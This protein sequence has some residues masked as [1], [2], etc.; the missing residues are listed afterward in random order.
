MSKTQVTT[1]D[2][3]DLAITQPKLEYQPF[4][5]VRVA[6]SDNV[7]LSG[8]GTV[9]EKS[10]SDNDLVL[11]RMQ[12]T[13][14]DNGIYRASSSAWTKLGPSYAGTVV[15]IQ[16]GAE[17]ERELWIVRSDLITWDQFILGGVGA[18]GFS[19]F[20]GTGGGGG[21]ESGYSGSSGKSGTSGYSGVAGNQGSQGT[22]G[23]S[24]TSGYSGQ[25]GT[26]GSQ[27]SSG[28]SGTSGYSGQAG[29]QGSQGTSGFSGTSGY[30]GQ[31]GTQGSQGTS[32]FSG[33]VGS[34]GLQGSSGYSG[35]AGIQ[36]SQGTSGFSGT[37]GQTGSQGSQGTSGF[38]GTSGQTGVQGSQG[39]SGFSGVIGAQGSQGT[40]GFSGQVGISGFS[41]SGGSGGGE[42]GTSGYSGIK[43]SDGTSGFSGKSGYSGASGV[44]GYSGFSGFFNVDFV[45]FFTAVKSAD[46]QRNSG[47]SLSDDLHLFV[48]LGAGTTYVVELWASVGITSLGQYFRTQLGYTGSIA[49][50]RLVCGIHSTGD[51]STGTDH[52]SYV[53]SAGAFNE[54]NLYLDNTSE[55]TFYVS[56]TVTTNTSGTLSFKWTSSSTP[57]ITVRKD[58]YISAR[59]TSGGVSGY[60]GTSGVSG[61]SGTYSGYSGIS[62][63]SG[64][65]GFSGT[66]VGVSLFD[67]V[68]KPADESRNN[69]PPSP[70][71]T[72]TDD[73]D[74]K[75]SLAAGKT[76]LVRL[77]WVFHSN[78]TANFKY[79][80]GFT[81]TAS[82]VLLVT[83]VSQT[84]AA[85]VLDNDTLSV[86]SSQN[87]FGGADP[88]STF[89]VDPPDGSNYSCHTLGSITVTSS[90][91]L[92]LQ[93]AQDTAN[94][95]PAVVHGGSFIEVRDGGQVISGT[96]GTSGTSGFSGTYSGFSGYSGKIGRAHV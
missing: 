29:T 84:A 30:S 71:S 40:S 19:G 28:F 41:G 18:S 93:W 91:I 94:A 61:F 80:F 37:S 54:V 35:V 83:S 50:S 77:G 75:V 64:K 86:G 48:S 36:G 69:V 31:A 7:G 53:Y 81:G 59:T 45:N 49:S 70:G 2:I 14:S 44:S 87:S 56:G 72:L 65:S 38:S 52:F 13:T 43:G 74:L 6:T 67:S 68:V 25:A 73:S 46:T 15:A 23:F 8:L 22:S 20:S 95:S 16:E 76:Y 55:N 57:T 51:D 42:S 27:G 96:S 39:T 78:T 89:R 90:G 85:G 17:H 79:R 88:G 9:D 11:V 3:K 92:S 32:G 1:P 58:S 47:T 26:L 63:Y 62:G 82:Q 33:Q 24:G 21:G 12:G 66:I 34:E 60:S 10:L 4:W 5:P